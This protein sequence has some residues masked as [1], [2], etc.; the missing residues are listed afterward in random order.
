MINAAP[1][2]AMT[3]GV[4]ADTVKGKNYNKKISIINIPIVHILIIISSNEW[5]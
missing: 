1:S 4:S 2:A 5:K 3:V